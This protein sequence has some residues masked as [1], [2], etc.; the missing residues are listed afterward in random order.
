MI[1]H[2]RLKHKIT[3]EATAEA[4]GATAPSGSKQQR[5]SFPPHKMDEK[6]AKTID[7]TVA[8]YIVRSRVGHAHVESE[9][10]HDLI[11]SLAPGYQHKVG[12]HNQAPQSSAASCR[13]MWCSN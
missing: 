13:C 5:F 7:S 11:D 10:F 2:L 12:A 9:A 8:Q 1:T 3:E 4:N 6:R